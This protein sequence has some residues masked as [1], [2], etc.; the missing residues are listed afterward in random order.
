MRQL[1]D[2]SL[3][4]VPLSIY[5]PLSHKIEKKCKNWDMNSIFDYLKIKVICI[6]CSIP[7]TCQLIYILTSNA[8]NNITR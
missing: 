5:L 7:I 1:N 2:I 6:Y 3:I 4:D 8:H